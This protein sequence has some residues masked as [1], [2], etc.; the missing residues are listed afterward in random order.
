MKLTFEEM[1]LNIFKTG[2]TGRGIDMQFK[3][4]SPNLVV[5]ATAMN[6]EL[7]D[8]VELKKMIN[9]A[10]DT[11]IILDQDPPLC[12]L[13]LPDEYC[14][15]SR[16]Y[17]VRPKSHEEFY[18]YLEY[19]NG[20]GFR[21][22]Q[23]IDKDALIDKIMA[24]G[25]TE[26]I[27]NYKKRNYNP[28]HEKAQ[29]LGQGRNENTIVEQTEYFQTDGC[30]ICGNKPVRLMSS[31]IAS[32]TAQSILLLLCEEHSNEALADDSILNYIARSV[33]IQPPIAVT[34]IDLKNDE[35][36]LLEAEEIIKNDM[37]CCIEKISMEDRTITATRKKSGLRVI[38]RL[39]S[40]IKSGYSYMLNVP[41]GSQ[42]SRIDEAPDHPDLDFYPDHRHTGLP[43][44]NRKAVPSFTTGHIR[45]DLPA[46]LAEVLRIE[47]NLS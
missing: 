32:Y 27:E 13:Y 20:S 4:L 28:I 23:H 26:R 16:L 35:N 24:K 18:K 14:P 1:V 34:P 25:A 9:D 11:F 2:L 38:I 21:A 39:Q 47:G 44:N 12:A 46:I 40:N 41:D 43:N 17:F 42:V 15:V 19:L 6:I 10:N 8:P 33:G 29:K 36:Y 22:W 30:L 37:E 31:T 3:S 45:L 5:S 7:G